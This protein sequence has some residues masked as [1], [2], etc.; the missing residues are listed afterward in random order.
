MRSICLSAFVALIWA[1]ASTTVALVDEPRS[2]LAAAQV[3]TYERSAQENVRSFEEAW[4]EVRESFYD[5]KLKGLDW[6]AIGRKY[7]LEAAAP[8]ANVAKVIDRMLSELK[9][10]HTGYYTPDEIA[11]YDLADIFSGGLRRELEK[12]FP[13]GEVAYDGIGVVT[14]VIDGRQF[15]SGIFNDFPAT[16]AGLMVGDEIITAD[17]AP[18]APIGSFAKKAGQKVKLTIRREA[19][20]KPM[21]VEVTPQRLRPNET[22][23]AAMKNGARLIEKDGHKLG[24]VHIW[25]YARR[26]YQ[27]LLEELIQGKFKDADALIWDLRD[28]WGGAQPDYLDIF[29]ARGPTMRLID[30]DGGSTVNARWRKPVILIINGGTRSGKEVL[31]YGFKKYGYGEVVGTRSAGALLAGRAFMQS[32]GSLLLIAVADVTVDNER[33]EGSGVAP[34]H[35]VPFDIRYAKGADPQLAAAIDI[36]VR[37]LN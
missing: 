26:Q 21:T 11:Y 16:K 6:D 31:T 24:Y 25:S 9:A 3:E 13:N 23:L 36:L 10:S 34:D 14:R 37:K 19:Q 1:L 15:I 33:L 32:N 27:E 7:R 30:R 28:G 18:F 2:A 12:R 20:G 17:G 8:K 4:R 5:R 35:E 29:N 22:F